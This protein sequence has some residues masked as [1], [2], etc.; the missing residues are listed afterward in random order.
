MSRA[1]PVKLSLFGG[2]VL[3]LLSGCGRGESAEE[4][5]MAQ[6]REELGRV[7]QTS[8]RMEERLAVLEIQAAEGRQ[9]KPPPSAPPPPPRVVQVGPAEPRVPVADDPEDTAP[10]PTIRVTGSGQGAKGRPGPPIIEQTIPDEAVGPS[11]GGSGHKPSALDPRARKEYEDAL[12][13]ARDKQYDKG[14]EALGAFL[15]R[16]PDH[17]YAENATYWR[18]EC[19][20]AKGEL[21]QA[22]EQFEGVVAR[23]PLGNKVPDA[24]LKLGLSYQKL[25]S[26]EKARAWFDRLRR[27]FPKSEAAG[28]IPQENP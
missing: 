5:S 26:K 10:R 9:K 25:Q 17:P 6:L 16:W 19:Y 15:L 13:L 3:T 20:F 7:Q 27:D 8:D 24:M 4:R 14:L 21:P 28:R 12:A 11:L 18:G 2:A 22:V 23:W 1:L